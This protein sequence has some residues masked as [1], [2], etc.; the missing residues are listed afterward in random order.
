MAQSNGE[1]LVRDIMQ[2]R[3]DRMQKLMEIQE[4]I[5]SKSTA[6]NEQ[7]NEYSKRHEFSQDV[8]VRSI[9]F[10]Q[11]RLVSQTHT[12]LQRVSAQSRADFEPVFDFATYLRKPVNTLLSEIHQQKK[13][14]RQRLMRNQKEALERQRC[15]DLHQ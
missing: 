5:Q 8:K 9:P 1:I 6:L 4:R 10:S 11:T 7:L 13:M 2:A 14:S 15:E 3:R 12:D